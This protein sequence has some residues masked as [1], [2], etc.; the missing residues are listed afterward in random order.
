MTDTTTSSTLY[1]VAF[2][3]PP[4]RRI[5]TP[6]RAAQAAGWDVCLIL[7]PSAHRWAQE[8]PDP[9]LGFD[10]DS[11][12]KLTGHPVRHRYKLPSQSDVLPS[13][14]ALLAAPLTCNS[15]NKWGAGISDTLA[16]GLLTESMGMNKPV[17]ALPH[18][19]AAQ[20]NQRA[21]AIHADRL[22]EDGVTLLLGPGG[23][24]PH[25]PRHSNPDTYP[26]AAALDALPDPTALRT[27][28][29]A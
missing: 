19:N 14:D 28:R 16:L 10:L 23:F 26:W 11:L 9:A 1:V 20:A 3:A 22:R 21:T 24:V 8:D 2:A 17:V 4:V 29:T 12:A 25:P 27:G 6:I 5:A 15:L 7:S 18:F 13:P